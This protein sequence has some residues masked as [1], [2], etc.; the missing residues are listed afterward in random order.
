[1]REDAGVNVETV[2]GWGGGGGGGD[3]TTVK[4]PEACV[5]ILPPLVNVLSLLTF[6]TSPGSGCDPGGSL[7]PL[8]WFLMFPSS[9]C[10]NVP[11]DRW[12]GPE[13]SGWLQ[14][15]YLSG[16]VSGPR[17]HQGE[18]AEGRIW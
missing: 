10:R 8:M 18:S 1:M 3:G 13:H 14:L 12:I 2:V 4:V 7:T 9:S 16:L 6:L 15:L 11:G 17:T 5:R